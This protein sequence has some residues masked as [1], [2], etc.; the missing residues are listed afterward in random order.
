MKLFYCLILL[1]VAK[2][3]NAQLYS[4]KQFNEVDIFLENNNDTLY[5][6]NFWATWCKP[7][8]E[9]LPYFEKLNA[10]FTGKPV[11]IIL[12]SLDTE[13]QW[14]SNLVPF[15]KNKNVTSTVWVMPNK[16]PIDWIDQVNPL[17]Q[18][19]IPATFIFNNNKNISIFEEHPFT[20]EELTSLLNKNN[21][22]TN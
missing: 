20:Y 5:I 8:I 18:G 9:E 3:S 12:L 11:K 13:K 19:S 6:V 22:F 17:W 15:L 10:D 21:Y 1:L 4:L 2:I 7:C 14:A 16:K